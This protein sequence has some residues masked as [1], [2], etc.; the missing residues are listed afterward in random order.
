MTP[1]PRPATGRDHPFPRPGRPEPTGEPAGP[2]TPAWLQE[3][4]LDQ[5]IVLLHGYLTGEAAASAAAAM[6]ALDVS[7]DEPVRLHLS[8]ADGDLTAVFALMDAIDGTRVPVH[9]VA[10]GQVGGAAIGVYAVAQRRLAHPHTRFWLTE[11]RIPGLGG[12]ADQVAAGAGRH[13]RDLES[14]VVRV[15]EA[16]GQP[17]SR[18]EDDFTSGRVLDT[19]EAVEYGLVDE[20]VAQSR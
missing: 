10:S 1:P 14:L 12:T 13:L 6:L 2:A 7:G 16:T 11:P 4:L 5:R 8:A 9:A 20:I 15:A 17:R 18:V 19:A 3:R